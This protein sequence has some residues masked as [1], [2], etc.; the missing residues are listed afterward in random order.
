MFTSL[1]GLGH[2]SHRATKPLIKGRFVWHCIDITKWCRSCNGCHRAKVARHN[3]SAFGKF[4]EPKERLDNVHVD[5]VGPSPYSDGYK[6][7]LTCIDRFTRWPEGIP[8]VD[9]KAET[10]G[11]AFFSGWIVRFGTP[12]TITTDRG[13]QCESKL[14]D[15]L[16]NQF[17][18]VRNH[19]TSYHLQSNGMV[20]RF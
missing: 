8:L 11:D 7:L 15:N 3:K 16:C 12:A 14:W 10:V 1:H 9:M 4:N 6:Y 5:I 2:P 13:A 17:G 20:E 18:I 19:T